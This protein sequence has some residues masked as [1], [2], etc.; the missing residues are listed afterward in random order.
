MA[1]AT[2]WSPS[3]PVTGGMVAS[4]LVAY[5]LVY[6]VLMAAYLGTLTYLARRA[7]RHDPLTP[8]LPTP[9]AGVHALQPAE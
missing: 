6:A 7:A 1:W 8:D 4:S 2:I 3:R 9:D 5:L